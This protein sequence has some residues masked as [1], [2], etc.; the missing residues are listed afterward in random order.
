[1]R[2]STSVSA[3]AFAAVALAQ[4]VTIH[5]G[6][7]NGTSA[8]AFD[9]PSVNAT[10]GSVITFVFDGMPGNHTVAQSAFNKPCEPLA[11]GFDSGFIFVPKGAS[12]PF[13]TW[14]LTITDDTKPIWFYCAQTGGTAGPHCL[15]GMVGAINAAKSNNTFDAFQSLAKGQSSV[16]APSPALSGVNALASAAP[17]PLT[18]S[19]SGAAVPTGTSGNGTSGSNSTG[20]STTTG[21]STGKPNGAGAIQISG[22]TAF[23]A[24]AFG[25]V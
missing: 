22:L 14:N 15:N 23:V 20:T 19:F 2:F 10:K 6:S 5:V 12:G 18:G 8:L 24:A 16:V 11:N 9:P 13:P 4:D 3:L 25:I 21:T 1:M 17:G 7:Q